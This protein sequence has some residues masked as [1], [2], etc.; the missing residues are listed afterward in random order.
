MVKRREIVWTINSEI[1]LRKILYYFT[2][3]NKSSKYS[4]KL[5]K[6]FKSQ[7]RI[8]AQRPQIGIKTKLA[9]IRGIII[10]NYILFYEI[11][12]DKIFVLKVWDCRQSPEKLN[13]PI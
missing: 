4:Q 9:N 13:I 3:R 8:V 7:L 11:S 6:Q 12:D 2:Q 1:Q 5:Y 10:D